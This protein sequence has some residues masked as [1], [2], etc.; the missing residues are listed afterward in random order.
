MSLRPNRVRLA[1]GANLASDQALDSELAGMARSRMPRLDS[2]QPL[3]AF[4]HARHL[5]LPWQDA[6]LTPAER[7]AYARAM[8][9]EEYGFAQ[10]WE[11]D[12]DCLLT[13][14]SFGAACIA[15]AVCRKT[16]A[17]IAAAAERHGLRL[18]A[19]R[20]LLAD[21][22]GAHRGSL[23]D[24]AVFMTAAPQGCEF[25]FRHDGQWRHAFSLPRAE[26]QSDADCLRSAAL[27]ARHFPIHVFGAANESETRHAI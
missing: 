21:T 4:P 13:Q 24:D 27:M 14:E 10:G 25:A 26:G 11:N 19:P 15:S 20:T 12:W 17:G 7:A 9:A 23:P 8:L 22:I 1:V 18:R 3:L 2:V 6:I 16:M 5:A